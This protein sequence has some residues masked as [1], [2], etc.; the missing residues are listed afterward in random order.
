M[1][2]LVSDVCKRVNRKHNNGLI[3]VLNKTMFQILIYTVCY[4]AINSVIRHQNEIPHMS[5]PNMFM[6]TLSFF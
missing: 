4:M 1:R 6:N 3:S 2:L 5:L